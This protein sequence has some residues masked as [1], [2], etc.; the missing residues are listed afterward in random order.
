MK[1]PQCGWEGNPNL[2][3]TGPHTK[4][5]C[6]QCGAYIKMVGKEELERIINATINEGNNN[7][8]PPTDKLEIKLM[9]QYLLEI[10]RIKYGWV[11]KFLTASYLH[12]EEDDYDGIDDFDEE[13]FK[14]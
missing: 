13:D 4:A 7:E 1:C 9:A 11:R 8:I 10:D 3:E 6:Q 12:V 2:E 14:D 5:T